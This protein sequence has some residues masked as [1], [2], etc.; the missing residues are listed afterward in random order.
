MRIFKV[1]MAVAVLL[2]IGIGCKK[3]K[4]G[5][6]SHGLSNMKFKRMDLTHATMLALADTPAK[7]DSEYT[8]LYVVNE[9]GILS[10]VILFSLLIEALVIFLGAFGM[11]PM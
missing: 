9:E 10:L 4:G 6:D 3:N 5:D 7:D 1:M 8:P 11:S 2:L